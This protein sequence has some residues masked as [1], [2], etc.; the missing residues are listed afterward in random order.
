MFFE[1]VSVVSSTNFLGLTIH[2]LL[3]HTSKRIISSTIY[4][5]LTLSTRYHLAAYV[6]SAT[7]LQVSSGW[8]S[9]S[10]FVGV[11]SWGCVV[12]IFELFQLAILITDDLFLYARSFFW[13]CFLDDIVFLLVY[14]SHTVEVVV[15]Q[16]EVFS[17]FVLHFMFADLL[18]SLFYVEWCYSVHFRDKIV[19]VCILCNLSLTAFLLHF[20]ISVLVWL[21][22]LLRKIYVTCRVRIVEVL[23]L[24]LFLS[25]AMFALLKIGFAWVI[26]K[27]PRIKIVT[28][29]GQGRQHASCSNIVVILLV[30]ERRQHISMSI[31]LLIAKHVSLLSECHSWLVLNLFAERWTLSVFIVEL[32]H[33][34]I[35]VVICEHWILGQLVG[36]S[37]LL[38]TC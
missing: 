24:D 21:V 29:F 23:F 15:C 1:H 34:S 31:C 5:S 32:F 30:V 25:V 37:V 26:S 17:C 11:E 22:D 12:H 20:E 16:V 9:V 28:S 35:L 33:L 10:K 4:P 3:L 2:M 7:R 8:N 36:L 38:L 27:R 13:P 18:L 14:D 19:L 6:S